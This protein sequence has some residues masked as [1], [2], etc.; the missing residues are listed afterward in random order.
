MR[1]QSCLQRIWRPMLGLVMLAMMIA[2]G[3]DAMAQKSPCDLLRVGTHYS[4]KGCCWDFTLNNGQSGLLVVSV[5]ATVLTPGATVASAS[6]PF[7]NATFSG[8]NITWSFPN[9]VP[10]GSTTVSGC[11]NTPSSGTITLVFTWNVAGAAPCRDTVVIDCSATQPTDTCRAI[12]SYK[13]ILYKNHLQGGVKKGALTQEQA[14]AK[15]AKWL[16]EKEAK[17]EGKVT[18]LDAAKKD[19]YKQ[20]MNA[21]AAAKAAKAEKIAAKNTPP[22][23]NEEPAA[24]ETAAPET[25]QA[26]AEA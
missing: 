13:G 15:F 16:S 26:E 21:E 7:N 23:A 18:K 14:D 17:V 3:T 1:M 12:L 19:A 10:N 5:T 11:F 8:N 2:G 25:P 6:G 4:G 24:E 9:Y 20:R 22:P